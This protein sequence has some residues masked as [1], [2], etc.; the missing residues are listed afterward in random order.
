MYS[1]ASGEALY[2]ANSAGTHKLT[3]VVNT[4]NSQTITGTKIF[5]VA[6]RVNASVTYTAG[7]HTVDINKKYVYIDSTGGTVTLNFPVWA[8]AEWRLKVKAYTSAITVQGATGNV[9]GAASYTGLDT[10]N[11]S[12]DVACDG[13]NF[14]LF[15]Q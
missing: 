2:W 10:T 9:D 3:N 7:T 12:V 4:D 1:L 5:T 6:P 14:W 13:T 15:G 11:E 8:G